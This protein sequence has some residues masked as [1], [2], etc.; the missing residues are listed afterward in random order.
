MIPEVVVICLVAFIASG[1]TLISGFGLGT[2]LLPVFAIFFPLD[3]AVGLTAIVH[4]LNNIFKLFL[5]GK[6]AHKETLIRF[7]IPSVIASFIGAFLLLKLSSTE[8]I[9]SYVLFD[10]TFYIRPVN[11][12]I[13]ILLFFFSLMEIVPALKNLQFDKKHFIAGGLLSGFFGG[14]SGH[15]GALRSAFLIKAGLSREQFLA[16]GITLA[17]FIDITRITVYSA[18]IQTAMVQEKGLLIAAVLSAFAGVF[19][20]SK[21]LKKI[22]ITFI[23]KIIGIFLM[24]FSVLIGLGII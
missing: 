20:V 12:I 2:I 3:I 22:T 9:G 15:Q 10:K 1:I 8:A 14:L 24:I 18:H 19:I 23:Q 13:S 11:V 4:F 5:L 17:C 7:G 6:Y 16:T 21:L